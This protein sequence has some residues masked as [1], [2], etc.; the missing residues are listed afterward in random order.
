MKKSKR[1][2]IV[3]VFMAA[4]LLLSACGSQV[5]GAGNTEG[6]ITISGAFALYPIMVR[7]GEEY[8][9]IYPNVRIDISAGGAGKGMA[10]ALSGAVD[11]GMVSREIHPEEIDLGAYGIA[12]TKDAVFLT[13]N[14]N[15]PVLDDLRQKGITREILVG[16]FISGEITTWGQVVGRP[17]VTDPIHVFTRS[18]ACGAADT[19]AAY[20]V[21]KQEDLLGIGVYGDPGVLDA[22]IKDPSGI[23]YNN[24]NYAYDFESGLPVTGA[25]VVSLDANAN[26]LAD[27][28]EIYD[29]KALAISAVSTGKYP[30]PP[31]RELYVVTNGQ[32]T[33]LTAAFIEWI[34][35]DGQQYINETGYIALPADRLAEEV[36]KLK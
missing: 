34:L 32:P 29:T 22:V 23:G 1:F 2:L 27:P 31:A 35:N 3:F 36:Q 26:G 8:Q 13:I 21:G 16:I 19:W 12:V 14:E 20:L 28:D 33:G 10:D 15:N 24:L 17:E 30:A 5:S 11:I 7:W 9:A 4:A 6:T 18:D 25:R